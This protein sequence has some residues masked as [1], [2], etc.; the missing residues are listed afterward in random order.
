MEC[1]RDASLHWDGDQQGGSFLG[2]VLNINP[3]SV[4]GHD[5]LS[6]IK[7][8]RI[9]FLSASAQLFSSVK[10]ERELLRREGGPAAPD[11]YDNLFTMT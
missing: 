5:L 7:S 11:A 6:H 10:K 4:L 1:D 8:H 2:A 9:D 3:A